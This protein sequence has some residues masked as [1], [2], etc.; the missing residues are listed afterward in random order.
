MIYYKSRTLLKNSAVNVC[1]MFWVAIFILRGIF[2]SVFERL[3]EMYL[4]YL[5]HGESYYHVLSGFAHIF[6][7]E[8]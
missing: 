5:F 4:F 8:P 7:L 1:S 3:R 2:L 6:Y